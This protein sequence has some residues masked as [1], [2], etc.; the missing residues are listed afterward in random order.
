MHL[1]TH[2]A[3]LAFRSTFFIAELLTQ[4][5]YMVTKVKILPMFTLHRWMHDGC[6][7]LLFADSRGLYWQSAKLIIYNVRTAFKSTVMF[8]CLHQNCAF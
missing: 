3:K 8:I 5:K 6:I 1:Q 4:S 2:T 7:L